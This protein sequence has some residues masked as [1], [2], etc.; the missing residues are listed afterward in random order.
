[1]RFDLRWRSEQA[2]HT[3]SLV[4]GKLN[5]AS[6]VFPR[7]LEAQIMDKPVGHRTS[8]RFSPGQM[9]AAY[10]NREQTQIPYSRFNRQFTRRGMIQPR[11]GR[12]Y[13]RGI[14]LGIDGVSRMD[15]SPFRVAHAADTMLLV[16]LNHPL[17]DR[18]LELTV[19]I[20]AVWA[21]R[22]EHGGGD[23]RG[24]ADWICANGPGMQARWRGQP[25]DFWSD[26]PFLRADP[27]PDASFYAKPRFVDHLDSVAIAQIRGLYDRLLTRD[28]RTLDLMTSWH[29]HLPAGAASGH[30]TGL[31]MNAEELAENPAL[32]ERLVHDLNKDPRLPFDDATFDAV[33]CTV[34][35]EYL[36]RPLEVFRE[37]AR[38][39]K[40]GGRFVV[41]F[42]NRWFPPKVIRLW[43]IV[44]DYER[45]GLV[46][47]YFLESGHF[48]K[49]ETWSLRGL[50]R[51]RDD[52]YAG[53]LPFSDPVYA[54]WAE[55]IPA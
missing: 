17:A 36:I 51:P 19:I 7:E 20:E 18:Q 25:T 26:T 42:S 4:A 49:L 27:R 12:F 38:V 52:K 40:P 30:V 32:D 21:R 9:L 6:A 35:V 13:P 50:P 34:S 55:R 31:G 2:R 46:S 8:H 44:H 14:L 16:D 3:D 24:I 48:T 45:L 10:Q 53:Q 23:A 5:L 29:S 43:E 1:M 22:G 39:L 28:G 15:R 41:T 11:A 47:E 37:V 54:V 33:V